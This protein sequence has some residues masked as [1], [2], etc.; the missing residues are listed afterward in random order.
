V[1]PTC[2]TESITGLCV[3]NVSMRLVL[4]LSLLDKLELYVSQI[5]LLYFMQKMDDCDHCGYP[6]CVHKRIVIDLSQ[7]LKT[8]TLYL[9]C[10]CCDDLVGI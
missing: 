7:N 8:M 10:T 9:H 6:A 4:D 5:I 3:P 2:L 1:H